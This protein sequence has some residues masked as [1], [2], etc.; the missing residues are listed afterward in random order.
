MHSRHTNALLGLVCL[1]RTS[2]RN[3]IVG[4]SPPTLFP[5]PI[6]DMI[7]IVDISCCCC[8]ICC[9]YPPMSGASSSSFSSKNSSISGDPV[10]PLVLAQIF[11]LTTFASFTAAGILG[12]PVVSVVQASSPKTCMSVFVVRRIDSQVVQILYF[13]PLFGIDG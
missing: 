9:C 11:S 5:P 2:G 1:T 4:P 12:L 7:I 8:C 6:M 3:G 13:F 10:V